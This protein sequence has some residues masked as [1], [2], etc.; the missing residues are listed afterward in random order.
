MESDTCYS[1]MM[2]H[3]IHMIFY[4][5][6]LVSCQKQEKNLNVKLRL[7]KQSRMRLEKMQTQILIKIRENHAH[8]KT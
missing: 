5:R 4:S 1:E 7:M 8:K 2:R 6:E 3:I